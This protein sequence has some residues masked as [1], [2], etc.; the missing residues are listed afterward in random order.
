MRTQIHQK[1]D[2]FVEIRNA[3][4]LYHPICSVL[5]EQTASRRVTELP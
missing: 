4:D 3:I 1:H 5:D 2:S